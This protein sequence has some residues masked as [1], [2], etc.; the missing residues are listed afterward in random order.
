MD[1]YKGK[2]KDLRKLILTDPHYEGDMWC[3]YHKSFDN[4]N[5]WN[6]D[7]VIDDVNY[8]ENY[9]GCDLNIEGVSFQVLLKNENY[10]LLSEL[11]ELKG[12]DNVSYPKG[13]ELDKY[14]IGMD[15]AQVSIGVNE[16]AER[17][18]K[19]SNW[20]NNP[21]TNDM[22]IFN[23]YRPDF[24]LETLTDGIFGEVR[25]FKFNN[26][27]IGI[28]FDGWLD[29]DTGYS[30]DEIIAYLEEN[31]NIRELEKTELKDVDIKKEGE[32]E[33]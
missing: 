9:K 20:V 11:I 32:L 31:M 19:Y 14:E 27:F 25:E 29:K 17:I 7:I 6:V 12:L 5:N 24:S 23:D 4:A 18:E 16:K 13:S 30:K 1:R 2:I 8:T 21:N 26:M 15:T 28:Q 22:D 33:V 3:C 10:K